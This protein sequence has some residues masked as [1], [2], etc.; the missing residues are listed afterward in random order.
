MTFAEVSVAAAENC[1]GDVTVAPDCGEQ[2]VTV[3]LVEPGVHWAE[4]LAA[5]PTQ[6]R[7]R[8]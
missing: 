5:K 1:T 2:M 4:L 8:T 3:L 6:N 7:S